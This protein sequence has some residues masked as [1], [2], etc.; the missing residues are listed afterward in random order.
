[1]NILQ[2]IFWG[3]LQGATE[4]LPVSSSGHLAIFKNL[5]NLE[6]VGI[7]FDVLLHLGTLIA[8]CCVY[9][10]DIIRLFIDGIGIVL[11]SCYNIVA[12]I[13]NKRGEQLSYKKVIN[14]T[15]RKFA[16]LIIISTIP[17]AVIGFLISDIVEVVSTTLIVPGICLLITGILLLICDILPEGRRTPRNVSYLNAFFIGL[18]QAFAI[19]PGVS[20][21]GTTITA[22]TLSGFT[23]EFAVKYSFIMSIPVILGANILKLGELQ[24][25]SN[26]E[27]INYVVG[28]LV[29]AIIGYLC[30]KIMLIV[31][32]NRR[33]Q[34]FAYYCFAIGA[35]SIVVY[36]I[37]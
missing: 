2:A 36:F 28:T 10:R 22:C 8:V 31:I 19:L 17:T 20:R 18:A 16:L 25:I 24:A 6:K 9:W 4:F 7:T 30:I 27:M 33:L 26:T 15:Y 29:S 34:Y 1:M 3:F 12:V 14:T 21:S 23:K 32:K 35:V 13:K 5:F 37:K 11:D